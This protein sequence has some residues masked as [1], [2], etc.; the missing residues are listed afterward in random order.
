MTSQASESESFIKEPGFV[1]LDHMAL[2][3]IDG[4]DAESFLQG[5]LTNDLDLLREHCGQINAYCT[6]KG[7][8]LAIFQLFRDKNWFWMLIPQEI[9]DGLLKRL[10]MYVMRAKVTFIIQKTDTYIGAVGKSAT[11]YSDHQ[12]TFELNDHFQRTLIVSESQALDIGASPDSAADG[13][14]WKLL[15]IRAGIPQ[16]YANTNEVF[17]PQN[18]N[19]DIIGGV[20]FRKGCYPGQE[21]VARLKYLGKSKQRMG[22]AHINEQESVV[23]GDGIF[24]EERPNQKSGVIVDAVRLADKSFEVS[25][26]VPASKMDMKGLHLNSVS[27]PELDCLQLP[28]SIPAE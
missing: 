9:A 4:A 6:P 3:K 20:S 19:L 24:S 28:Y 8:A 2:I 26:M 11:E 7:R 12:S 1:N 18:V 22:R 21:I 14:I 23:P 25:A 5:Q 27:G 10:K 13:S 16:V 15:D 17:I